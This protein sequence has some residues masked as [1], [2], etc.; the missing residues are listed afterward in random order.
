MRT[1]KTVAVLISGLAGAG[2]STLSHMLKEKMYKFN[3]I[4]SDE[5]SFASPLKYIAR[6]YIGW[7][8]EKDF[9]GR[10]L[11]Q[12]L[13]RVGREYNK[14]IWSSRFVNLTEN[15]SIKNFWFI[16]DWRFPDEAEYIANNPMFDVFTVRIVGRASIP[17]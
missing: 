17:E 15:N 16:D 2:K 5:Y 10:K 3:G 11:L 14:N 4:E 12:N 13:G 6:H 8:G 1:R 7:S 9:L